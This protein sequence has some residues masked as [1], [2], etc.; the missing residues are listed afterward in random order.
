MVFTGHWGDIFKLRVSRNNVKQDLVAHI[1]KASGNWRK[2]CM[3]PSQRYCGISGIKYKTKWP[4]GGG[5]PL[6]TH[7]HS[8]TH[9]HTHTHTCLTF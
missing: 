9:T 6:Y 3:M 8:H 1:T 4:A 2:K 7:S 5:R